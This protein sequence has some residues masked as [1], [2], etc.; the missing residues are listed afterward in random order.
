MSKYNANKCNSDGYSFD[1]K[2]EMKYY[3]Y[4]KSLKTKGLIENFE[5]QPEYELI[6]K[7]K[8]Y[9]Y[10]NIRAM[11]YKADFVIYELDYT[12]TIIDIKGM[13]TPEAKMKRKLF[14]YMYP[15][16]KLKWLVWYGGKWVDY[17]ENIKA[18]AKRKKAKN[19]K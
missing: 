2:I 8:N 7:F 10:K 1:S 15:L 17:D 6:P 12:Q 3:E 5:L 11:V 14:Y 13:A 9:F 16:S 4:L 19:D 18:M